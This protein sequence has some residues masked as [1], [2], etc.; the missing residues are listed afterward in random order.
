MGVIVK[1]VEEFLDAFVNE[2]V[3]R[4]VIGPVLELLGGG[5]FAV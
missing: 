4:D 2:G 3:V 1:A 5:E